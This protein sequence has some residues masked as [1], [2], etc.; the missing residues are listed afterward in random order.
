MKGCKEDETGYKHFLDIKIFVLAAVS[1]G[2]W[3]SALSFEQHLKK[4][5]NRMWR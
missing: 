5:A 2:D 4:V 1:S 3:L